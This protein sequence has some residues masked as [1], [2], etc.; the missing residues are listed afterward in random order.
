MNISNFYIRMY[1]EKHHLLRGVPSFHATLQ[2]YYIRKLLYCPNDSAYICVSILEHMWYALSNNDYPC[3]A[4][5]SRK[6]RVE[7]WQIYKALT[8][9]NYGWKNHPIVKMWK[10][11][12]YHLLIYGKVICEEWKNRGF[13]DTMLERFLLELRINSHPSRMK[14][15]RKRV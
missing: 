9:D 12:E 6:Q 13:K 14:D 15:L 10:G 7:A 1:I 5:R 3:P 4:T 11:Y 2:S 8:L